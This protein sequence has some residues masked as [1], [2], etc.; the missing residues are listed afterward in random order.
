MCGAR[1]RFPSGSA[2]SAES[3]SAPVWSGR[4]RPFCG[5][6]T[7]NEERG[8]GMR[9]FSLVVL[10]ILL[11]GCGA[12]R[13]AFTPRA[14]VVARANDHALSVERLV[15]WTSGSI[16]V[17]LDALAFN[18]VSDVLVDYEWLAKQL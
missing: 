4:S 11:V 17:P 6:I 9:G 2:G 14:E 8:R 7:I 13:D 12:M 3:R 15:A 1:C 16:Q 18:R 10:S 5:T